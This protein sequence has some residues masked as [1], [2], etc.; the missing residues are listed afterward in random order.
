MS[1]TRAVRS[2]IARLAV[3]RIR[4]SVMAGTR[5]PGRIVL[6]ARYHERYPAGVP[7]PDLELLTIDV[8][9]DAVSRELVQR[10]AEDRGRL[11]VDV[12]VR[13]HV[14]RAA[15]AAHLHGLVQKHA[16]RSDGNLGE[17]P[18]DVL[19]IEPHAAVAHLHAHAPGDVGAV[20]AVHRHAELEAVLAERVVGVAAGDERAVV[21]AFLDVLDADVFGDVPLRV[22][23]LADDP[24][25]A[26]RRLPVVA[27]E[28]DRIG[29]DQRL[30]PS[31][32][33]VVAEP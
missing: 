8:A 23:R 12:L 3:V 1:A 21:A 27:T 6:T 16:G 2:T 29:V 17:E 9:F 15:A 18:L 33:P 20:N 19:G 32:G 28:P 22:D 30:P 7:Q 11:T 26:A 31:G 5:R 24:E 14:D 4:S 13:F 10:G 25:G